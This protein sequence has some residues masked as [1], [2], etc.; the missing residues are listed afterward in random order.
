MGKRGQADARSTSISLPHLL[1]CI[2]LFCI[3]T[4]RL[5]LR[6]FLDGVRPIT[7]VL[8]VERRNH[9]PVLPC[10][11]RLIYKGP[12]VQTKL[13]AMRDIDQFQ[14]LHWGKGMLLRAR[15]GKVQNVLGYTLW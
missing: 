3:E 2:F 11:H 7:L 5:S 6:A 13:P 4:R 9:W 10:F 8:M 12:S 15:T 1:N 14:Y